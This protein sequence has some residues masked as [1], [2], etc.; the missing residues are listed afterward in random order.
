MFGSEPL[1]R[2]HPKGL[3]AQVANAIYWTAT[4]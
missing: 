1:F 3:Y 2:A 4:R